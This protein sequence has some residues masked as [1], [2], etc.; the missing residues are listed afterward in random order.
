[1]TKVKAEPELLTDFD[2]H[3]NIKKAMRGSISVV[4]KRF[5]K[6]MSPSVLLT[7]ASQTFIQYDDT[8]NLCSWQWIWGQ[9][10]PSEE[11]ILGKERDAKWGWILEVDLEHP[12]ELHEEH[13]SY[14]IA[15]KKKS[16]KA[17]R[18]NK[19]SWRGKEAVSQGWWL[20]VDVARQESRENKI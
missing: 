8:N 20:V 14:P 13:D 19:K 17:C 10:L 11:Q 9:K 1:M 2:K 7:Q 3:L 12:E 5:P 6:K 4:S 15:P 18:H 16:I